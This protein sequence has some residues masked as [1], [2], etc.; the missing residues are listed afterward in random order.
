MD[1]MTFIPKWAEEQLGK[2]SNPLFKE[3]DIALLRAMTQQNEVK[4][5]NSPENQVELP[6]SEQIMA[7]IEQ[8]VYTSDTENALTR[9]VDGKRATIT[10]KGRKNG[11][12]SS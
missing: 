5:T 7:K 10:L 9:H 8:A 11:K 4:V 1:G 3:S 12:R 2:P 6:M